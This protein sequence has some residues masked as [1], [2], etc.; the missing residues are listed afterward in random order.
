MPPRPSLTNWWL[1]IQVCDPSGVILIQ[2]TTEGL[3][4]VCILRLKVHHGKVTAPWGSCE[5]QEVKLWMVV[6]IGSSSIAQDFTL[7]NVT[8][9]Y[10]T[11]CWERE[12]NIYSPQPGNQW[13]INLR[14]PPESNL[15]DQW[16]LLRVFTGVWVKGYYLLE[17]KGLEDS[18]VTRSL[19]QSVLCDKTF[20][21]ETTYAPTHPK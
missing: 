11:L 3:I 18:Y 15:M 16:V 5:S 9:C 2:T 12:A 19:P 17:Q 1:S 21:E 10:L 4:L 8:H 6:L 13:Q 7:W 14:I 20:H